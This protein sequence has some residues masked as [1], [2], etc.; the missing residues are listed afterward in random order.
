M[1]G[2]TALALALIF[3]TLVCVVI[4]KYFPKK[5][6]TKRYIK[7]WNYVQSLCRSKETW[8]EAIIEA[9]FLL[10]KTV[11]RLK[12]KGKN[13]GEKLTYGQRQF[14]DNDNLWYSYKVFKK[15]DNPKTVLKEGE[16]K[17]ALI[18]YRQA[19]RDL[20][21]LPNDDKKS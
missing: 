3:F 4:F 5:L 15:L 9:E 2:N 7:K 19:L 6:N 18:G 11:S 20:G 10:K 17:K 21:A 16:V 8:P 13:M 12:F 1:N 14:T